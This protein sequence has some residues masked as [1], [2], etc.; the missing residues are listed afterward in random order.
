MLTNDA[1]RRAN[2]EKGQNSAAS[3][4]TQ[5]AQFVHFWIDIDGY[6]EYIAFFV[7]IGYAQSIGGL[8]GAAL[9]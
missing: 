2:R 3:F 9:P 6:V 4:L 7:I 8:Y 5:I 1:D